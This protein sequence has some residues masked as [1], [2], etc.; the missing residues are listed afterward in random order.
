MSSIPAKS[1]DSGPPTDPRPRATRCPMDARELITSRTAR[2]DES[3]DRF[4]FRATDYYAE[5]ID[6]DNP[7]DPIRQ[8]IIPGPDEKE[9]FRSFVASNESANT[10]E[11]RLQLKYRDTAL[12]LVTGPMRWVPSVLLP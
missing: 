1:H 3:H 5:L 10:V 9:K 11:A 7:S 8:L 6:W 2:L 12:L 4:A